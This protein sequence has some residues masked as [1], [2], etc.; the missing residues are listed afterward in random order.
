MLFFFDTDFAYV[1]A[2]ATRTLSLQ[3]DDVHDF[4]D[5][6]WLG[7]TVLRRGLS[8]CEHTINVPPELQNTDSDGDKSVFVINDLQEDVFFCDRPF[9]TGGPKARFYAGVPI[10]TPA[11]V[12][13]GV[14]C[15]LDD[16]PRDGLAPGQVDFLSQ[17][18]QTVMSHLE[19]LRQRSE[20]AMGSNMLTGLGS[21]ITNSTSTANGG[22][23]HGLRPSPPQRQQRSFRYSL[24]TRSRRFVTESRL[25]TNISRH[26]ERNSPA[27]EHILSS[28]SGSV[29]G[30]E[31]PR[32]T[33]GTAQN[34]TGD[35]SNLFQTAAAL[36]R[37]AA[38][39][40]GSLFLDASIHRYGG[41][42][43]SSSTDGENGAL[44]RSQHRSD[45]GNTPVNGR[46]VDSAPCRTLGVSESPN[47]RDS[48]RLDM[49]EQFLQ[50]LLQKYPR[51]KVWSFGAEE[52]PRPVDEHSAGSTTANTND[53]A[54]DQ[55]KSV[56]ILGHQSEDEEL[57]RIFPGV[58]GLCLVGMWD[59]I[60]ERWYAGTMIWTYSHSRIFFKS[61][62]MVFLMAFCDVLMAE[63]TR[64]ESQ[65]ES[66]AK[67]DFI[68]SISHELR[69][70]LQ[71]ILC[72]IDLLSE[73]KSI[74]RPL[75]TQ[76]EQC[77]TTLLD[78]INHV[79]D[80]AN[81]N[82]VGKKVK[83]PLGQKSQ[84]SISSLNI[85]QN[86][87]NE[88]SIG[89]IAEEMCDSTFYS[90]CCSNGRPSHTSVDL[91]LDISID[92]YASS[93]VDV[94]AWKRICINIISNALKYTTEGYV[95]VSLHISESEQGQRFAVLSVVDTGC[96]M[97]LEF[98][99]NRLFRAFEQEDDMSPGT[100]LGMSLVRKLVDNLG[101]QIEIQSQKHVGTT[102]KIS[103]P[104]EGASLDVP[105]AL[106]CQP[107]R[108]IQISFPTSQFESNSAARRGRKLLRTMLEQSCMELG[109]AVTSSHVSDV[110][111][112][113]ENDVSIFETQDSDSPTIVL[114][115]NFISA[116]NLQKRLDLERP[117]RYM[118]CIAQ[119]Y[120]IIRL[121][122]AIQAS[123]K[124]VADP[125][126]I[127]NNDRN[128][129]S[130]SEQP[131]VV[132][133]Q[134]NSD[135]PLAPDNTTSVA[136]STTD[137][138]QPDELQASDL[139]PLAEDETD[140][141]LEAVT[142]TEATVHEHDNSTD[143]LLPQRTEPIIASRDILKDQEKGKPVSLLLVDDNVCPNTILSHSIVY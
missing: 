116:L 97:S 62:E 69:S 134:P 83:L 139:K 39:V 92:A 137:T 25:E 75:V 96:G 90:H 126:A 63:V 86:P 46:T 40:D 48:T 9:V 65:L 94:G 17:M 11:N 18:A 45:S 74:D 49:P 135:I 109:A 44:T 140:L 61:S 107:C 124:A 73:Q 1:L 80:F 20:L 3:D 56:G 34:A 16:K 128:Y 37:S 53:L 6:L 13:I 138:A 24:P 119:P 60:R 27:E 85:S 15:V 8:I 76:I 93:N 133:L 59:A 77:S 108:G 78:I 142:N 112:I 31:S 12:R 84:D 55:T 57:Q 131:H 21:L 88:T 22:E 43:R 33:P 127:D 120:G 5:S 99:N 82:N 23:G 66:K 79:L 91:I 58:R 81:I 14:Y 101:G 125:D 54:K 105:S 26:K 30:D 67:S 28:R 7:Y 87:T 10:T 114:C 122:A 38:E 113:F 89:K 36:L 95:A 98:M 130:P 103:I 35:V 41:T 71:G 111:L 123:T 106:G 68:S 51:G 141:G 115:D 72:G 143:R 64:L 32:G 121:A 50:M 129:H 47:Q 70:P 117:G 2:E 104:I 118:Q 29:G 110:R 100:G 132:C 19:T 136:H 42:V 52:D 4:D 102:A